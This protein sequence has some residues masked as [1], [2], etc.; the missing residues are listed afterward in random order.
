[1]TP[2][3]DT[4]V[5]ALKEQLDVPKQDIEK[6]IRA[7]LEEMVSKMDLVS[8]QELERHQIA[9]QQATARLDTL[10]TQITQLEQ[11]LKSS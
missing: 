3:L 11:Q 8:Q 10:Q 6:N 4:F 7:V 9:L 1:M 2:M 5:Q